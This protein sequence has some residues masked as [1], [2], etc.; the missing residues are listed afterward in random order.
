M[1]F[2]RFAYLASTALVAIAAPAFAQEAPTAT[3]PSS[4][5]AQNTDQAEPAA[6]DDS[7]VVTGIRGSL[8]NAINVKRQ[9]NAVVDVI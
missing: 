5:N 4:A 1:A 7:I 9:A 3:P 2:S 6:S 8:R